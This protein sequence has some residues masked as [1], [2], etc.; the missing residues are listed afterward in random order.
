L[1]DAALRAAEL[2]TRH[3]PAITRVAADLLARG[4]LSSVRVMQ[5]WA[6]G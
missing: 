5:L 6:A 2:V 3:W 4:E 1:G